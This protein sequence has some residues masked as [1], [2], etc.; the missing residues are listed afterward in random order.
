MFT[1]DTGR[2]IALSAQGS[3]V[4]LEIGDLPPRR[5][6]FRLL[7]SGFTLARRLSKALD[8]RSLTLTVTR[9]G[10]PL[11]DLGSGVAGNL[12]M[13]LLGISRVRTYGRPRRR[14]GQSG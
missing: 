13:R 3:R 6:T 1:A 11:V 2:R 8:D 12:A 10:E 5:T 7:R 14:S 9:E 4:R